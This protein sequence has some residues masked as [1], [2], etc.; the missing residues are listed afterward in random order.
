VVTITNKTTK[1]ILRITLFKKIIL[2]IL[3]GII[4]PKTTSASLTITSNSKEVITAFR[5]T[6]PALRIT[7]RLEVTRVKTL[8]LTTEEKT[9]WDIKTTV[10]KIISRISLSNHKIKLRT[11]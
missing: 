11:F 4:R 6:Q 3:E 7:C 9:T 1:S 5:E 10:N 2:V 8:I